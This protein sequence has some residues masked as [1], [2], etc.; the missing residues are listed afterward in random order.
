M[1][2]YINSIANYLSSLPGGILTL[3]A[4]I[5]FASYILLGIVSV[6]FFKALKGMAQKTKTNFDDFVIESLESL[7]TKFIILSSAYF[8][9]A[10]TYGGALVFGF[11]LS[12]IFSILFILFFTHLVNKVANAVLRWYGIEIMPK[13]KSTIN[14]EVFPLMRKITSII[15]YVAGLIL[16]LDRLGIEIGPFIAGLGIAGLAV[17]LALQETLSNFFAGV[18]ILADKPVKIGDYIRVEKEENEGYVEEVGWRSTK[19]KTLS[20]NGITI[21][22]AKLAQSTITNFSTPDSEMIVSLKYTASYDSDPERVVGILQKCTSEVSRHEQRISKKFEPVV[23]FDSFQDSALQYKI[24]IAI[25]TFTDKFELMAKMNTA[26]Y[27]A[28]KKN[29]IE[30]PYPIRMIHLQK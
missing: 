19:I 1:L 29:K 28:F 12:E 8:A 25:T 30:I 26:V 23:R 27:K 10:S 20:G 18:Y 22:N 5:F 21:P 16:V 15:I 2:S 3:A 11:P 9:L 24:V 6:L 17:A 4:A 7:S 13:T 14:N